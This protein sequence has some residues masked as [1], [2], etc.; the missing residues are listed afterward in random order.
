MIYY[1]LVWMI[2]LYC[3]LMVVIIYID[4]CYC[5]SIEMIKYWI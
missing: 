4:G 1:Q 2:Q 3:I 5:W